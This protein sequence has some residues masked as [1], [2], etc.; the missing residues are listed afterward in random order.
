M[1]IPP[2]IVELDA[3]AIGETAAQKL[4]EMARRVDPNLAIPNVLRDCAVPQQY[5]FRWHVVKVAH[6]P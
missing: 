4:A 2:T 3:K 6:N 1:E 5:V